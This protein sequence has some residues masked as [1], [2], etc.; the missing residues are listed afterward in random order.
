MCLVR[1]ACPIRTVFNIAYALLS[2]IGKEGKQRRGKGLE[3]RKRM[4]EENNNK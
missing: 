3:D 4:Q 2:F 1:A